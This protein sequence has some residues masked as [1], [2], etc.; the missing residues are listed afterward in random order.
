MSKGYPNFIKQ[1]ILKQIF[2]SSC[3]ISEIAKNN[4]IP[5][6]TVLT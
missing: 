4:N 1:S 6:C 3:S 2:N 5:Y